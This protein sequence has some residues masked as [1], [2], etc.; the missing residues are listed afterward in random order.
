MPTPD[1]IIDTLLIE[2]IMLLINWIVLH[3]QNERL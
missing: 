3:K 1:Y 2:V